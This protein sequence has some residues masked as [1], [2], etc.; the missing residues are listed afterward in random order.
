MFYVVYRDD[1]LKQ[2][3]NKSKHN[4]SVSKLTIEF[5]STTEQCLFGIEALTSSLPTDMFKLGYWCVTSKHSK[6]LSLAR[7]GRRMPEW[8]WGERKC[9][10][11]DDVQQ[12]HWQAEE[13]EHLIVKLFLVDDC[14]E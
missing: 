2:L 6:P 11:T 5:F 14:G 9:G 12:Q 13:R 3:L 4:I 8:W 10:C 1:W 7:G